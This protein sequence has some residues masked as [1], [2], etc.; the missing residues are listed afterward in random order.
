M[1]QTLRAHVI[2]PHACALT[3]PSRVQ[4]LGSLAFAKIARVLG[5]VDVCARVWLNAGLCP[6]TVLVV[7]AVDAVDDGNSDS[8]NSIL[9][10]VQEEFL[11]KS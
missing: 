9:A 6:A 5:L 8:Q 4:G 1:N 7:A 2:F 11:E 10:V 3:P